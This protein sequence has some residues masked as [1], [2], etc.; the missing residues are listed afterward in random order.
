MTKIA[1]PLDTMKANY[2][3]KHFTTLNQFFNRTSMDFWPSKI[4]L[5]TLPTRERDEYKL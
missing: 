3:I 5:V 2:K 1:L 4:H